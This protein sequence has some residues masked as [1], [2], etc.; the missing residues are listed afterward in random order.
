MTFWKRRNVM[1]CFIIFYRRI[2]LS[3]DNL[4]S[5]KI[6]FHVAA[7]LTPRFSVPHLLRF[8]TICDCSPLFKLFGSI[9]TIHYLLF[10]T[11][12]C[13]L[14]ATTVFVICYSGFPDT[15]ITIAQPLR[16]RQFITISDICSTTQLGCELEISIM[17]QLT[18]A[19]ALY[20]KL[21]SFAKR[22]SS[23]YS[24]A[25]TKNNSRELRTCLTALNV[26]TVINASTAV[27]LLEQRPE[28]IFRL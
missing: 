1:L 28:K 10:G 21:R 7:R 24:I 17:R 2:L 23:K 18:R 5:E 11:I 26:T 12:R 9:C 22:Q 27:T 19:Q 8:S 13:S 4:F 16:S 15:P 3:N 25:V 14:L 20:Y 6:P